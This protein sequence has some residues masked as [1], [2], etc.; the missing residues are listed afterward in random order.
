M[1]GYLQGS[2][3]MKTVGIIGGMSWEST[4]KYYQWLNEGVRARLGG[5]HSAKIILTSV[6]FED[7]AKLQ[8]EQRWDLAGQIL[9]E[10]ARR[11]EQAG[12]D[13]IILATNT[14]HRVADDISNAV[15]IPFIHLADATAERI[16]AAGLNKIAL[17]GTRYTMEQ[18][19]YKGR[20]AVQG[21]EVVVPDAPGRDIIH[22]VIYDE[23]CLGKIIPA[24][25]NAYSQ[26][27]HSLVA[28]GA[29][30]IILG[31][32]EITLLI[33]ADDFS[34]PVFDTTRIHIEKALDLIFS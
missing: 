8:K 11:L 19:F 28:D 13:F 5:L 21:I 26:I 24:S 27:A 29:Q 4:A 23:L 6:N 16:R 32:T 17:L 20:L 2:F 22:G 10:E 9:A 14:M 31:C 7:I 15:N 25:K 33:G 3:Q 18:D 30:G 34:F 12:A 1:S